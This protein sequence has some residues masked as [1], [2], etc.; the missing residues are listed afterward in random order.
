MDA[1]GMVIPTA[2]GQ[3]YLNPIPNGGKLKFP[4]IL[5]GICKMIDFSNRLD[6]ES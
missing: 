1:S 3:S 4:K 6:G 2:R 5:K